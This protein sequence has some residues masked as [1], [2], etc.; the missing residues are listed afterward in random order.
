MQNAPEVR[1]TG[2]GLVTC[3]GTSQEAT[4]AAIRAGDRVRGNPFPFLTDTPYSGYLVA[5][6][7]EPDLRDRIS[8]RRM[9]KFMS[10]HAELAAVAAREALAE[11]NLPARG[12]QPERIG[13][14]AGVGL[15]AMDIT[16][17]TKLLRVS[18]SETG[19][20]SLDR[21][22]RDG[23]RT[24][25]PLWSFHTL[26][27]MPACIVSVLEGIKGDNGIYTPWEDQ[28]AFALLE[29]AHALHEGTID[30]AVVVASDTPSHPA[31]MVDLASSGFIAPGEIVAS[32]A[33]C[34][35]LERPDTP[36]PTRPFSRLSNLNLI[37]SEP[38]DALSD[39]LAPII[40][41]TLAAAPLILVI[42]APLLDLPCRLRGSGGHSFSFGAA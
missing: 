12:I 23:L 2:S 41:R 42:L 34:L 16:V 32:G 38:E 22:C 5:Q 25:H 27:N 29:A 13:L 18:L 21:F 24:I 20:F 3:L 39:P 14:Y 30:A 8:D 11:A 15:A 37:A 26:A 28:T 19:S 17:S 1:I 35:V 40:G 36:A 10:R 4:L 31:S 9:R 33:A 6:E 7:Q